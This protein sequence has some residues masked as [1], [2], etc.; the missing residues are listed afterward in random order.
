VRELLLVLASFA[1]SLVEM[2]EAM[3]IV[4]AVGIT[5]GWRTA[6]SATLAA[7]GLLAVIVVAFGPLLSRLPLPVLRLAIG[8]LLLVFGLQWLRKAILRASGWKA[9][10]DED[11]IFA[12]EVAALG[13]S[14]PADRID[15]QGFAVAF[16]G[17][18]LEG[19]EVAFIVVTF[20]ATQHRVGLAALGAAAA[21]VLV[22][23]IGLFVHRPLARVPENSLKM[24]VGIMLTSFGAF[25][26]GEGVGVDWP[27]SDAALLG[28]IAW[29]ALSTFALIAW[30]RSR[31]AVAA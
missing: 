12:D 26:A 29:V 18:L 4:L 2:V 10:H 8:G 21:V 24:V 13:G 19:L 31:Q 11:Q 5:K 22:V 27:G 7:L 25:W 17:V 9:L 1:A 23:V 16:K 3:T 15:G 6:F 20:G 14:S 30:A 28:I